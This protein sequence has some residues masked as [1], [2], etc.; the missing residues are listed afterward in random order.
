MS[1]KRNRLGEIAEIER[2]GLSSDDDDKGRWGEGE[3]GGGEVLYQSF[4]ATPE[5]EA[6]FIPRSPSDPGHGL[7]QQLS[8]RWDWR[9]C[10]STPR[11]LPSPP[12]GTLALCG[13]GRQASWSNMERRR[14][15]R[16]ACCALQSN[17][18]RAVQ[19]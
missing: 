8:H 3:G 16:A 12:V 6:P 17:D 10:T 11:L 5:I 2:L 15:H 7:C 18:G 19:H 9:L 13:P 4:Q 1:K 14:V